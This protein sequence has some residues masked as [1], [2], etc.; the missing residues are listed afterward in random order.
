MPATVARLLLAC[1]LLLPLAASPAKPAPPSAGLALVVGNGAYRVGALPNPGNDARAVADQ[2]RRAGFTVTLKL[3]TD[4]RQLQDAIREHVEQLARSHATGVFYYAGH[5]AQ[6]NWRNFLVPVDA[7]VRNTADIQS[8]GVDL[9][10]LIDGLGRARNPAN[11]VILDACRNNPFGLDF[12]IDDKGLSQLDAPPGTLLAYATAPG[13]TA[14]DGEGSH[15]L[16]TDQLLREMVVPGA[17][18]ED[19]FKRVRLAV[20]RA[21]QGG[22]IPWESTSLES[23]FAFVPGKQKRDAAREFEADLAAWTELSQA[24]APEKLEAFIRQRP[25]GKFAELAQFRLDQ[26]LRARGERAV[27]AAPPPPSCAA[28]DGQPAVPFRIGERYRYRTSNL[29][30]GTETGRSDDQ[31]TAIADGEVRF[32]DGRKVVDLFGNNVR[33]PDGRRW[34]PYQFFIDD[35]AL[36]KRW[37]AQFIVTLADGRQVSTAFDLRVAARER[38]TIPAGTFD[39]LRIEARGVDLGDGVVQ[40]RNAWVAPGRMRG[41]LAMETLTRRRGQL[42]SGERIELQEYLPPPA[43][44]TDTPTAPPPTAV[45]PLLRY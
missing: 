1:W 5:G 36:G 39:A 8:Q 28:G 33:A 42:V 21:S 23:D 6:L 11:I 34:T 15:G 32:G 37:P 4:R 27:T 44:K 13:N 45:N 19:V 43:A 38:I 20:R 29:L 22:Q 30:T 40:E 10:L 9:G 2:L 3:D 31:V 25:G 14:A 24:E 17:A 7:H 41:Y 35:Y 12:R 18:V 26:L 16:Y